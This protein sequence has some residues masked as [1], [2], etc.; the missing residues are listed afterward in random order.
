VRGVLP[1]FCGNNKKI[2]HTHII[3]AH[4]YRH[5]T[6]GHICVRG[7]P[8]YCAYNEPLPLASATSAPA[9]LQNDQLPSQHQPPSSTL[10]RSTAQHHDHAQQPA[11]HPL[12]TANSLPLQSP[13]TLPPS[14]PHL[15]SH[16]RHQ[17]MS[18]G[19][20]AGVPHEV[21]QAGTPYE[22]DQAGT[23]PELDQTGA[24]HE[25]DQAGTLSEINQAGAPHEIDQA[26]ALPVPVRS[27]FAAHTHTPSFPPSLPSQMLTKHQQQQQQRQNQLSEQGWVQFAASDGQPGQD[28]IKAGHH[29]KQQQQQ[30]Q[31]LGNNPPVNGGGW[32]D[33]GD[34]GWMDKDG[35][36]FIVG[37]WGCGSNMSVCCVLFGQCRY[38]EV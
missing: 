2:T 4:N 28:E 8:L 24:P 22:I 21:Y 13:S 38:D 5:F 1:R 11:Q 14:T 3:N 34:L 27:P 31:E 29:I 6:A 12:Q 23:L 30:Q 33:T 35:M 7:P 20:A 9:P 37:R 32:F 25:I 19:A 16:P 10:Q 36:L 18:L 26:G 15:L 17:Q